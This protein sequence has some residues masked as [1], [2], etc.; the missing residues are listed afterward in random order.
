MATGESKTNIILTDTTTQ[1]KGRF[2]KTKAFT[3]EITEFMTDTYIFVDLESST[4][5]RS[6]I[7][8]DIRNNKARAGGVS[9]ELML[10]NGELSKAYSLLRFGLLHRAITKEGAW[11]II[12]R[13]GRWG[14]AKPIETTIAQGLDN[15]VQK[16]ERNYT[17]YFKQ[18]VEFINK[19]KE[20]S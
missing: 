7:R 8:V 11:Y 16:I 13:M 14:G 17:S 6:M 1:E 2:V 19:L 12:K 18:V 4:S 3:W 10:K 9:V 5:K 15:T 20:R